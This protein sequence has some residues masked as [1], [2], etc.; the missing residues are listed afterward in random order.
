M[1]VITSC[2]TWL[3][4]S[5]QEP[6]EIS[7]VKCSSLGLEIHSGFL[8]SSIFWSLQEG[9]CQRAMTAPGKITF[10]RSISVPWYTQKTI[11]GLTCP[12]ARG[13]KHPFSNILIRS[14]I[15]ESCLGWGWKHQNIVFP[16]EPCPSMIYFL[17]LPFWQC[18][19]WQLESKQQLCF[20]AAGP[21]VALV[22]K[23]HVSRWF[24]TQITQSKH[25]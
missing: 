5:L 8:R 13:T 4:C 18:W 10:L 7:P 15:S 9:M 23:S 20:A 3:N 1:W 21:V 25:C 6:E 2:A 17:S 12:E 19:S 22:S 14:V 16:P 11:P 24:I